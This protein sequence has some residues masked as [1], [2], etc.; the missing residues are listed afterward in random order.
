MHFPYPY[1][2]AT[3]E[4]VEEIDFEI[5]VIPPSWNFQPITTLS[6]EQDDADDAV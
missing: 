5:S 6:Q 2:E 3:L 4:D 1:I